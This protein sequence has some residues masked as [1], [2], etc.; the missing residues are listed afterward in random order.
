MTIRLTKASGKR[1]WCSG[2]LAILIAGCASDHKTLPPSAGQENDTT[3]FVPRYYP[4]ITVTVTPTSRFFFVGGQVNNNTGGQ[5]LYTGPITLT[6][7]LDVAGNFTPFADKTHV[8]IT[9]V[10]GTVIIV[11]AVAALRH[12]EKDPPIYP[13]DRIWVGRRF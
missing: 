9:R 3:N 12:P 4:G 2:L 10:D 11:N 6:G 5:K 13:G 7:A 8:Q 1:S